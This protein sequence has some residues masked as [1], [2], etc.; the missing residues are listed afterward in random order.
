MDLHQQLT[1]C[2]DAL[3]YYIRKCYKLGQE[4]IELK[5][6]LDKLLKILEDRNHE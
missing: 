1:Q 4:N 2:E 3:E 5:Q 6:Q